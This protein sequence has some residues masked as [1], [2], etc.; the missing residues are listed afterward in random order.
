MGIRASIEYLSGADS[1][2]MVPLW[3]AMM[4]LQNFMGRDLVP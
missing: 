4:D 1:V 2:S 3:L